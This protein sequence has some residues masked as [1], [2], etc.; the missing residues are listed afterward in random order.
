MIDRRSFNKALLKGWVFC[1]TPASLLAQKTQTLLWDVLILPGHQRYDDLIQIVNTALKLEKPLGILQQDESDS[2]A[3]TIARAAKESVPIFMRSGGHSFEGFCMGPGVVLDTRLFK[4]VEFKDNEVSLGAG[5][6]LAQAQEQLAKK[7]LCIPTGSCPTVG[8]TGFLLGGGHSL[9]SRLWGLGAD[10]VKALDVVL[11]NGEKLKRVGPNFHGDLFWALLGGGGGNFAFVE[12]FHIEPVKARNEVA[13]DLRFSPDS[14]NEVA[15]F[16]ED[17]AP[18][19]QDHIT[20]VL[21]VSLRRGQ[22]RE[23]RVHGVINDVPSDSLNAQELF[24]QTSWGQLD[25]ESQK[26]VQMRPATYVR[27][28][29]R[30]FGF[31]GTSSYVENNLGSVGLEKFFASARKKMVDATVVFEPMG[32]KISNPERRISYPHRDQRYIIEFHTTLFKNSSRELEK[33]QR[34]V[35]WHQEVNHLLSQRSYVNYPDFSLDQWGERYYGGSLPKLLQ[36]KQKYDPTNVFH[37]GSHSLS[38]YLTN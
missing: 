26:S 20:A 14:A 32:G 31:K 35:S 22:I 33:A 11:A 12:K 25:L 13:F 2:Y 16:W 23:L 38:D 21:I 3:K 19:D 4:S 9:K 30:A 29:T 1:L 7:G 36:V 27:K 17:T 18:H 5:L 15:T 37:F 24:Q 28:A 10:R 34:L 8:L 6:T